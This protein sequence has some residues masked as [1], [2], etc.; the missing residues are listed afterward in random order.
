MQHPN[1]AGAEEESSKQT[2]SAHT[3]KVRNR[4]SEGGRWKTWTTDCGLRREAAQTQH[5]K[6]S[7]KKNERTPQK[8]RTDL[9]CD[10]SNDSVV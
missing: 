3:R 6:P 2:I 5:M 7:E 4:F 9:R 1:L 8:G 10:A